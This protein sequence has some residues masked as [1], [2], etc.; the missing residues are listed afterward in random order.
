M[1]DQKIKGSCAVDGRQTETTQEPSRHPKRARAK[2]STRERVPVTAETASWWVERI[3]RECPKDYEAIAR[4]AIA[5]SR[6]GVRLSIVSLFEWARLELFVDR[7]GKGPFKL[8]NTLRPAFA[9]ALMNDYPEL[10]GKFE[11]RKSLSDAQTR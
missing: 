4:K 7:K 5:L 9:R 10:R 1:L 11:T 3:K 6:A 8:D 2:C